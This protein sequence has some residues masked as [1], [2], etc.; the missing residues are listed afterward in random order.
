MVLSFPF[1][2]MRRLRAARPER[3][4]TGERTGDSA[5]EHGVGKGSR[6]LR[7]CTQARLTL[8][9]HTHALPVWQRTRACWSGVVLSLLR[10]RTVEGWMGAPT[11]DSGDTV[12]HS[13]SG[14]CAHARLTLASCTAYMPSATTIAG[15][16]SLYVH[17]VPQCGTSTC[18]VL[19]AQSL[20]R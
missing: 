1:K 16:L 18:D 8:M 15:R 2:A 11:K 13:S 7:H 6:N 12:R 10:A 4:Y 14:S 9:S 20:L 19:A 5:E 17:A 3:A